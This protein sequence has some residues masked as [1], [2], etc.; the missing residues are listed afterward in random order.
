MTE[1]INI[2][3]SRKVAQAWWDHGLMYLTP[4]EVTEVE[5]ALRSGIEDYFDDW[6]WGKLIPCP[7]CGTLVTKIQLSSPHPHDTEV[8]QEGDS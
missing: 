4:Q 7:T 5:G 1:Y 3:L 6:T 2:K 8:P